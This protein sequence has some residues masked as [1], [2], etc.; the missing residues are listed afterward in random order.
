MSPKVSVIIPTYNREGFIKRA[1]DS[2]LAQTFTDYE[3]IVIDDGSADQTRHVLAPYQDRIRYFYQENRGISEA[4][5]R[6]IQ[7]AKGEYIAFL[8]SDDWW[9]P[10]KLERQVGILDDRKTVGL[11]YGRMPILD[12]KG[13]VIGIKPQGVSGKNFNE[14]IEMWGDLPTSTVITRRECFDKFGLFDSNLPPMED[15]DMWL[16]IAQFYDLHEVAG[17]PLAYYSR[18]EMQMTKDKKKVYEGL[19]KIY[20]KILNSYKN[21][22]K[23]LLHQRVA[24]NQYTLSRI[25]FEEKSYH[26]AFKNVVAAIARYPLVGTLFF[27]AQDHSYTKFIK[28]LK[29]YGYL[30][31]ALISFCPHPIQNFVRHKK[32][33]G[34]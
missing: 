26:L 1:V 5:N 8:D 33:N 34:P 21:I 22:P 13:K 3:I 6:G 24:K 27:D 2:V 18:H 20:T 28:L 9:A 16:R 17:E 15:I 10:T 11:V 23:K 31:V 32:V 30:M 29:P 7:E 25:Y 19:V 12:E 14:L 4:R